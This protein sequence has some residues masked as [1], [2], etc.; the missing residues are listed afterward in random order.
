M[1]YGVRVAMK[2]KSLKQKNEKKVMLDSK[3]LDSNNR[4]DFTVK[5]QMPFKR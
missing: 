1:V 2:T 3:L 5:S 4:T